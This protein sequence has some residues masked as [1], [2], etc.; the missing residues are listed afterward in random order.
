MGQ[1]LTLTNIC[2]IK[3]KRRDNEESI[4][5]GTDGST[6]ALNYAMAKLV[7]NLF[8]YQKYTVIP[9]VRTYS[10]YFPCEHRS[11][12]V[13]KLLL[14]FLFWFWRGQVTGRCSK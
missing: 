1:N 6:V 8:P 11:L 12:A 7:L 14:L 5:A 3:K 2:Q 4:N 10:I 9:R 13:C